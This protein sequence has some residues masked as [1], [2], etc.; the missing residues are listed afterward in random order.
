MFLSLLLLPLG[1]AGQNEGKLFKRPGTAKERMEFRRPPVIR[2]TD[3]YGKDRNHESEWM[4]DIRFNLRWLPICYTL[5]G[6]YVGPSPL[7]IDLYAYEEE[8]NSMSRELSLPYVVRGIGPANA[9]LTVNY[10]NKELEEKGLHYYILGDMLGGFINYKSDHPVRLMT[11]DEI[12][13]EY[14]PKVKEGKVLYMINKFFILLDVEY[15]KVAQEFIWDVEVLPSEYLTPIEDNIKEPFTIIRIFT[16]TH[17]NW[18]P[19]YIDRSPLFPSE[20]TAARSGRACLVYGLG[21]LPSLPLRPLPAPCI[22]CRSALRW[23]V[24]RAAFLHL[25]W[26]LTFRSTFRPSPCSRICPHLG[27][28]AGSFSAPLTAVSTFPFPKEAFSPKKFDRPLPFRQKVVTSWQLTSS[29]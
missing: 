21:H 11:L 27:P 12:R 1:A 2:E 19:T 5:N 24:Q 18:H 17:H 4:S 3:A 23:P 16:K 13:K 8:S 10:T 6:E 20:M 22:A 9:T 29:L 15:Y 28:Q 25:Q 14:C 26:S 7:G